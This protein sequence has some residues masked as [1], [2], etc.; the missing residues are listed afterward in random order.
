MWSTV[1][2]F[3]GRY[4][5]SEWVRKK[6]LQMSDEDIKAMDK[7]IK[8]EQDDG[9]GGPIM[10]QQEQAPASP[11]EYPPVDNTVDDKQD[12]SSTPELDAEVQRYSSILNRK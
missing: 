9:V 5:S 4:F 11:D 6:I 10:Q 12:E 8:K 7:Q 3:M 2:P 1:D